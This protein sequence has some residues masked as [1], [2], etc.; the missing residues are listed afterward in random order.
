MEK[1]TRREFMAAVGGCLATIGT[2]FISDRLTKMYVSHQ[3]AL[4]P[5]IDIEK[6]SQSEIL[7]GD[8]R[9]AC[10]IPGDTNK[11][12]MAKT[13]GAPIMS[14]YV[15]SAKDSSSKL[16]KQLNKDS[17]IEICEYNNPDFDINKYKNILCLG[18]PVANRLT[19]SLCGYQERDIIGKDADKDPEK[20]VVFSKEYDYPAYFNV[21]DEEIGFNKIPVDRPDSDGTPLRTKKGGKPTTYTI[22]HKGIELRPIINGGK[23]MSDML[24]IIRIPNPLHPYDG[25]IT[26][27]GGLHGYSL[28][29]FFSE[30]KLADNL[31]MVDVFR[32]NKQTF[33][34]LIP[35]KINDNGSAVLKW[36]NTPRNWNSWRLYVEDLSPILLSKLKL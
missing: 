3:E 35:A 5:S 28:R 16:F 23:L 19:M 11:L 7:F 10:I 31:E 30:N 20:I 27:I 29:S 25:Y 36:D 6:I 12:L 32:E 22:V 18:G 13:Q 2:N 21:G 34:M 8:Y 26:I 4:L 1:N 33:Q 9:K 17:Q 15:R 24:M 14:P